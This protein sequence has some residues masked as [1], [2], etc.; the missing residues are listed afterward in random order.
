[1]EKVKC[2]YCGKYYDASVVMTLENGSPACPDCVKIEEQN[3][4]KKQEEKQNG[5]E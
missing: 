4:K 2:D 1:M 5:N 3:A